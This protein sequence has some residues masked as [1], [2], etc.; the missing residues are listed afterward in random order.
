MNV[1]VNGTLWWTGVASR[2]KKFLPGILKNA[3]EFTT[4]VFRFK[5]LLN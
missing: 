3:S 4:T 5:W 1:C 2:V